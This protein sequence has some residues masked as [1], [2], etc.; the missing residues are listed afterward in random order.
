MSCGNVTDKP[1]YRQCNDTSIFVKILH[2]FFLS[3]EATRDRI[4]KKGV[5]LK[6]SH[7]H[8]APNKHI[9]KYIVA[10]LFASY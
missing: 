2:L 8:V 1:S 6:Q 3:N 10:T 7:K 4:L 5:V 9:I